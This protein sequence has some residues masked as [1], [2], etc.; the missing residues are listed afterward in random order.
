MDKR[1]SR[2]FFNDQAVIWDLTARNND[3]VKLRAMTD[4]LQIPKDALVLDVGT[5]TGVFLPFIKEKLNHQGR[6][7]C[8][9]FAFNMVLQAVHKN[10]LSNIEY[11]CSEIESMRFSRVLFDTVICYSTFPHFHNKPEAL[12]NIHRLM[13]PGGY[14]HICHTA[15]REAINNI[16]SNIPDFRDHLLPAKTEMIQLALNAGFTSVK[17]EENEDS[18]LMT[19]RKKR[20]RINILKLKNRRNTNGGLYFKSLTEL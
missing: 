17:I 15:S 13:K 16:H 10:G 9:D 7:I 18:Y 19:G 8:M 1:I 2:K 4:R 6:I 14:L 12:M 11:L 20:I 5:G 3:S